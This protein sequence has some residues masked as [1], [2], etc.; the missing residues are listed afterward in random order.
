MKQF[1]DENFLLQTRTSEILYHEFAK[2]LPI[3]DYHCHLSPLEIAENKRFENLTKIWLDGDH[4]KWR[5]MRANGIPEEYCTGNADD[6]KKFLKWAETVPY[7]LR[8]PLYHWTHLELKRYFG[9]DALLQPSSASHIYQEAGNKLRSDEY[10]VKSLL[11]KMNVEV[12]CTTDDPID[13]LEHHIKIKSQGSLVKV[14]PTWRPDKAMSAENPEVYNAYIDRLSE[15]SEMEIL[16]FSDLISALRKRHAFFHSMGCRLSDHGMETFYAADYTISE[17]EKIFINVRWGNKPEPQKLLML[18]SA[19][20]FELAVMDHEKGWTQ[21]FHV[22]A[23]RNNNS[24]MFGLLGPDKGYDSIGDYEMA[25]SMSGFFDKLE[26]QEKLTKTI[27]Y[28]LNPRDNELTATMVGNFNDGLTPGKMQ[29]G[30]GWWFMDQ[31]DGMEKQLNTLSSLGLLSRFV[32]MLTDSRCFLSFPRHEY[33]RRILCNLIGKD[34]ENGEL[35]ND[36]IWLGKMVQDISYFN[37]R[38]YFNISE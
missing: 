27:V 20:L 17:V 15:V 4:Y 31:K 16:K 38:E 26:S 12:V 22:G 21:Q 30:S 7:T 19:I 25:K 13:S 29:F 3:I 23:F 8:N 9:I 33:F 18:K 5:A 24:R 28:N 2:D 14:L 34:V 11:K 37:A 36:V 10:R 35:P 1:M 6:D 32:G